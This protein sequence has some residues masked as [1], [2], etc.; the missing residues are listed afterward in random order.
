M[1]KR[2]KTIAAPGR[3]KAKPKA[4]PKRLHRAHFP[5]RDDEPLLPREE[6]PVTE[7]GDIKEDED[8]E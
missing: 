1:K 4:A 3:S 7:D 5:S 2:G 8:D 6:A